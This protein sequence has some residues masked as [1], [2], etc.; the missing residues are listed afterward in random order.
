MGINWPVIATIAA[1]IIA[2]FIGVALDRFIEQKPKLIAY[3]THTSAFNVPGANPVTIHT[4][5]IVIKNIGKRPATDIRVRHHFLPTPFTVFPP[6]EH[7]VQNFP[8][9]GAEI[10]FPRLVQNEQV[11]V[12]YLYFPPTIWSQIH[13]G[14]RHSDGFAIEVIALPTPPYS[15]WMRRGLQFFLILGIIAFIYVV[16]EMLFFVPKILHRL[17]G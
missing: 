10:V 4:H 3:F 8:A 11:T 7:Q 15:I 17:S 16:F 5:G 14:I 9:G 2:L 12:S 1:P 13:A 6:I